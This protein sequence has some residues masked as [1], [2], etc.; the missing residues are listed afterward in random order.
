MACYEALHLRPNDPGLLVA[1]ADALTHAKR[2]GEA[3]GVYRNALTVGADRTVVGSKIALAA[4]LR[5]SLLET[6]LGQRS[7]AAERACEAAWLPGATDEVTLFKRRALL[8]QDDRQPAA[9]LDA[10]LS[11]ARL[12]PNDRGVA[13]AIL[14]LTGVTGR[15][16]AAAS[17]ALWKAK[18]L[19]RRADRAPPIVHGNGLVAAAH[20]DGAASAHPPTSSASNDAEITRSN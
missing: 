3:I 15:K 5:R 2:A 9:A 12:R 16:D 7:A 14:N 11:A 20:A 8:L 4:S 10:Y 19:L 18:K 13:Q 17:S 1:E 6:C